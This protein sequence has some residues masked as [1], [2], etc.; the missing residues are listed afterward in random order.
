MHLTARATNCARV[1]FA[2]SASAK[3]L[4]SPATP[5]AVSLSNARVADVLI[6][7][8]Q[9]EYDEK[10][11]LAVGTGDRSERIRTYN[12]PQS[13]VTDHRINY[14]S[15][16]LSDILNGELDDIIDQLLLFE[17]QEK[18]EEYQGEV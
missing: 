4:S 6:A 5:I 2:S 18:M 11:K 1:I 7:E 8:Q 16:R 13:R 14:S 17:Q 10:R 15:S 12:F 9:G 3:K